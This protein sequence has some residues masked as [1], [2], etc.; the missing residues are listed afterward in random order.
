[1][2]TEVYSWRVSA[3]LKM[4]LE[5]EALR[6]KMSV[7]ALLD[8]AARDLPGKRDL[9]EDEHEQR[10]LRKAAEDCFGA[11]AGGDAFASKKVKE[12]VRQ[13]VRKKYGR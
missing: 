9:D 3:D 7:S 10:R 1:M 5:Q 12:T 8:L 13:Q 6:R 4:S 11:F 2:K